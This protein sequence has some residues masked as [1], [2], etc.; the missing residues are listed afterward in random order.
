MKKKAFIIILTFL[1][2]IFVNAQEQKYDRGPYAL[3]YHQERLELFK[4]EPVVKG[5]IIFLGDSITEFGD[6]QAILSDS[7]VV[8][9][10]IAGDTT[11]GILERLDDVISRQ[12][13]KL[14]LEVGINDISKNIPNDIIAESIFEIVQKVRKASPRT[15][16]FVHSILPTNDDVKNEYPN[17]FNKNNQVKE[18][19]KKLEKNER[20]KGYK[21]VNLFKYFSDMKDNLK[22]EYAQKDGIHLNEKGYQ[23]WLKILKEKKYL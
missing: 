8:N 4:K 2:C 1:S 13:S 11:F 20:K 15:Q 9:R 18:V 12:P 17:A 6:W 21:F 3:E 10:G 22:S 14:F 5:K 16:I 7:S 23:L 19:N